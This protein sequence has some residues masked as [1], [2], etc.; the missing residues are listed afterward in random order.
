DEVANC[1]DKEK[2]VV[3]IEDVVYVTTMED[4]LEVDQVGPGSCNF[5]AW[6]DGDTHMEEPHDDD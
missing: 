6:I 1:S 3:M 4:E 5:Q 2:E